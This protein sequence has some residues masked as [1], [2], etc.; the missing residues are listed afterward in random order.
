MRKKMGEET[1][2]DSKEEGKERPNK[3]PKQTNVSSFFEPK[4]LEKGK[5]KDINH[6][7]IKTF[8]MCNILFNTVENP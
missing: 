1:V 2:E 5:I 8:M 3:K 6:T 7:I 4:K